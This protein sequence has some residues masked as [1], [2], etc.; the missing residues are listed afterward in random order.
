MGC[1]PTQ[2]GGRTKCTL[3]GKTGFDLCVGQHSK[4]S[5]LACTGFKV[6]S[7][8]LHNR[9]VINMSASLPLQ[10]LPGHG[11][12]YTC[13]ILFCMRVH[14]SVPALLQVQAGAALQLPTGAVCRTDAVTYTAQ[15]NL[16]AQSSNCLQVSHA[17]ICLGTCSPEEAGNAH[18]LEG[19]QRIAAKHFHLSDRLAGHNTDA[20]LYHLGI[21]S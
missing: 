2:Y 12:S 16:Q 3:M 1:M 19:M 10:N 7:R 4:W 11:C 20:D 5:G 21:H 9:L 17:E 6:C 15:P 18:L 8:Y 14:G 13:Y